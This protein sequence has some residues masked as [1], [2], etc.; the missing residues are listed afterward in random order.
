MIVERNRK[1]GQNPPRVVAPT[2]EE[3]EE[4]DSLDAIVSL[5][6]TTKI[7]K[8]RGQTCIRICDHSLLAVNKNVSLGPRGHGLVNGSAFYLMLDVGGGQCSRTTVFRVLGIFICSLSL[9]NGHSLYL[10]E[11]CVFIDLFNDI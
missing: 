5:F 3:E 11:Y 8:Q 1:A 10:K 7:E 9:I 4:E 6:R 2:E